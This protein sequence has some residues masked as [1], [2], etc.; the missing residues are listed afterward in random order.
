[1]RVLIVDDE[2]PARA[3]LRRLLA[4]YPA[5]EVVGEAGDAVQALAAVATL[6]PD[7]LLLDVQMPGGSGLDVAASLPDP[8]PRIVFVTAFDRY[9]L[10]AFEAAAL[11]Y[12]LK[13]VDPARL[14]R[15]VARWA[16][17][18]P[19]RAAVP[20]PQR[21]LI[22]DRG[23][24]LVI[25]TAGIVRLEA[26]DN[27]V[28]LHTQA[29]GQPLMRRTL[30]ALVAD[31]GPRFVRIHRRHAVAVDQVLALQPR[32]RGDALLRLHDGTELPVSRAFR[33]PLVQALQGWPAGIAPDS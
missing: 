7:L 26:A 22:A 10:P 23:R 12:L 21:L 2:P 24:T 25:E 30:A 33:A 27:Y 6:T 20:S 9:A 17:A 18:L 15:S 3:R 5:V 11:D 1:M 8:A 29:Q 4:V 14:A 32:A 31:L 13:P 16:T 28:E 19:A